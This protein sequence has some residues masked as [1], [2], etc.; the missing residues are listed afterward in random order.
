M[1]RSAA[2]AQV[3]LLD[4]AI[5]MYF[6]DNDLCLRLRRHGW[7]VFFVPG[8]T[9]RHFNRPSYGDRARRQRYYAGL[10][11]FYTRH[12]G[13]AAGLTVRALTPVLLARSG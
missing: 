11:H 6:E 7:E 1:L 10:A 13:V 8:A 2:L 12:Y 5:F 9:V 4:E 3:G